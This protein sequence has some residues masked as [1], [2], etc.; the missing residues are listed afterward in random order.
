[1]KEL[2]QITDAEFALLCYIKEVA[3]E[4]V[5]N[6]DYEVNDMIVDIMNELLDIHCEEEE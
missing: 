1:M 2:I 5:N 3:R 4:R 6:M